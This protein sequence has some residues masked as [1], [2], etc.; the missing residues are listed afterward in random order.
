MQFEPTPQERYPDAYFA[1]EC[2]PSLRWRGL[3]A[4]LAHL[5]DGP[6]AEAVDACRTGRGIDYWNLGTRTRRAIEEA[7]RIRFLSVCFPYPALHRLA[8]VLCGA[9]LGT[10]RDRLVTSVAASTD[11]R[12]SAGELAVLRGLAGF[13]VPS[14]N[15]PWAGAPMEVLDRLCELFFAEPPAR[16]RTGRG[17]ARAS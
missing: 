15:G 14:D 12:L 9:P 13:Q 8:T 3:S 17:P 7:H 5:R 1:P 11:E 16:M 10:D 2:D 4:L 6:A